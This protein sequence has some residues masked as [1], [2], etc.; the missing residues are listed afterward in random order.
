MAE[1]QNMETKPSRAPRESAGGTSDA[2][3]PKAQ[4]AHQG[5]VGSGA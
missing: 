4:T 2:K 1:K 5:R 3:P